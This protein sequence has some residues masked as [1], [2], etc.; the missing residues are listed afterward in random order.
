MGIYGGPAMSNS[1]K[2]NG[3]NPKKTVKYDVKK[4]IKRVL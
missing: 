2:P 3:V 4:D 1:I